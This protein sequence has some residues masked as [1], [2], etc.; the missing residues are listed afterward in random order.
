[1]KSDETI[2]LEAKVLIKFLEDR[3]IPPMS[4]LEMVE[5]YRDEC[6]TDFQRSMEDQ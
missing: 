5:F 2:L 6:L 3:S 1:M 4:L